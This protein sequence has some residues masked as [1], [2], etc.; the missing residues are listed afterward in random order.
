M[1]NKRA[2]ALAEHLNNPHVQTMLDLISAAEST[3]K[4]GYYTMFG[5]SR[6]DSLSDHPRRSLPFTQTDGKKNKSSAAGRYQ[7]L[8]GTWDDVA[9]R[10]GLS[11]F[12]PRNQ[13]LAAIEL[14]RRRGAL[15]DVAKGDFAAAIG[16]LGKEWASLP[17]S[18]YKQPKRSQE[19]V[20]QFL[21]ANAMQERSNAGLPP[22]A[23][24]GED[25]T[26]PIEKQLN[27]SE[28]Q[29]AKAREGMFA[30]RP[31]QPPSAAPSWLTAFQTA[32]QQV[33]EPSVQEEAMT[34]WEQ[35]LMAQAVDTDVDTIRAQALANFFGE[36]YSPS[37]PLP[38]EIESSLNRIIAML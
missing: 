5:G 27:L 14:I 22:L 34:P 35:Q 11:D 15:D 6:L 1:A 19:W 25:V 20:D 9:K 4:H 18:T 17:T 13:D 16:K 12:S 30:P 2:E 26:A 32:T 36:D 23:Q 33:A 21:A 29:V 24:P 38:Q 31:P 28:R 7:F 3:T 8:Q 10:L 37:V